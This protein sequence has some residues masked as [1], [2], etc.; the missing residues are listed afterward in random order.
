[1]SGILRVVVVPPLIQK[2]E[3][4]HMRSA[5]NGYASWLATHTRREVSLFYD[6]EQHAEICN[7]ISYS[8]KDS[9]MPREVK[10]LI[11][12]LTRGMP[13]PPNDIAPFPLRGF[14]GG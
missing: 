4:M 10:S 8:V 3:G 7:K 13:T 9:F 5:T 2:F 1:M 14:S 6:Y 11:N 12:A